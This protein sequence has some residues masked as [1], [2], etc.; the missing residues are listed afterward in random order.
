MAD[1]SKITD[2]SKLKSMM[3]AKLEEGK[4]RKIDRQE[5]LDHIRSRIKGQDPILEDAARLLYLQMA[6]TS[7][8]KPIA[9][10]LFLGPTG[11]GKTELAKAI[12]E[13]LFE[14][15]TNM[16]RIDCAEL[17]TPESIVR[18]IGLPIGYIG[19]E[20]GGQL[21][22]PMLAKP[23]RVVLFDEIEKAHNS[24]FDI[25]LAMLGEGRLTEQSSGKTADFTQSV[26][27][28]TSNAHA[29]EIGKIQNEVKDPYEM[30]NAV[31]THLAE[32]QV[33]RPEILGRIDRIYVFRPLEGMMVAEI[34]LLQIVRLAKQYSLAVEFIAPELIIQVLMSNEKV[35]RFGIR[36]MERVV[37]DLLAE[38]MAAAR[39]ARAK[40]IRLDVGPDGLLAV[41]PV[42]PT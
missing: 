2:W 40:A 11:T 31:K 36:E 33:F 13:Y 38:P 4:E 9:S 7:T 32:A 27:I 19:Y 23:R 41:S 37:F 30:V 28:L 5:L 15:E 22:R 1:L 16:L 17:K 8:T 24:I 26:V 20:Q 25:F 14:D 34:A 29:E 10:L 3:D 42:A 35:R 21:T 6:K 39:A 18:L 12:T